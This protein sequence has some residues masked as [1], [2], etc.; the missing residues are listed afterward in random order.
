[1][2]DAARRWKARATA[3]CAQAPDQKPQAGPRSSPARH[4]RADPT[5]EAR[6]SYAHRTKSLCLLVTT[7]DGQMVGFDV[8]LSVMRLSAS[9]R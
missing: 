3:G 4:G 9:R 1:M 5:D 8:V 2:I 7:E 6:K